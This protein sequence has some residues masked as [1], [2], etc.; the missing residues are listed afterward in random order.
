[1]CLQ[2]AI[3]EHA[4]IPVDGLTE[5]A[6]AAVQMRVEYG[7]PITDESTHDHVENDARADQ[8]GII[9]QVVRIVHMSVTKCMQHT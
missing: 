4:E 2:D 9:I 8:A 1:M 6:Q 5:S 7:L 3:E